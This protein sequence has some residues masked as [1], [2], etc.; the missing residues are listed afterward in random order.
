[1]D[2]PVIVSSRMLQC[3][4]PVEA[5]ARVTL[6]FDNGPTPGVTD[7]VLASLARHGVLATFFVLGMKV[8]T[9]AGRALAEAAHAAGHRIGNHTFSHRV[10][11]GLLSRE[12]ALQEFDAAEAALS[13]LEQTPRLFRPFG[14]AGSFGP[15]LL[16]PA[17]V[18]RLQAGHFN[19]VLWN[20]VPGDWRDAH[21]WLKRA[22]DHC[23]RHDWSAVVLHDL[24]IGAM[25][26]LD[27]FLRQLQ[28]A[29]HELV[30][31]FPADCLPIVEGRIVGSLSPYVAQG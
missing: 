16:H 20:C 28:D 10:P 4:A 3:S 24:P 11:L 15:H 17:V 2:D 31:E 5:M 14:G 22:L 18:E 25:P 1:V 12:A 23:R 30:Q 19:C 8:A 6:S 7:A 29:G 13:W 26:Q 9:P 21:G 27:D